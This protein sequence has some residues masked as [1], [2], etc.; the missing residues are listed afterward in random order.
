[1]VLSLEVHGNLCIAGHNY[2]NNKFF[3]KI[4]TLNINDEIF[5]YDNSNKKFTYFV[6]D[7]YEVKSDDLSPIYSYDKNTQQLTLITCNNLN[8]N[9]IIVRAKIK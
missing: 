6:S 4:S 8:N 7:I 2:D 1:M 9:R 3:S 5:I